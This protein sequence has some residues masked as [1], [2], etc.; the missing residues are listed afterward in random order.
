MTRSRTPK[1]AP[2]NTGTGRLIGYARVSTDDQD[3]A[4][5]VDALRRAGVEDDNIHTDKV[6]AVARKRPGLELA[7]AD[8]V[9]GDTFVVWRL[10]RLGRSTL[11]LL[12]RIRYLED[13]GIGFRSLTEAID[14]QTITGRLLL[15][16]LGAVAEFERNLIAERT[17][18][19]IKAAKARGV[20]FGPVQRV[21]VAKAADLFRQGLSVAQVAEHFPGTKGRRHASKSA[22]HR[23]FTAR[24]VAALQEEGRSRRR[25]K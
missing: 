25:R 24:D 6:S 16:V 20:R 18:S 8:A 13:N 9:A 1:R 3:L 12:T 4:M 23:Y 10:D 11:D 7:L 2:D 21:D 17:S 22:I 19:G 14:T 5:Q 15:A